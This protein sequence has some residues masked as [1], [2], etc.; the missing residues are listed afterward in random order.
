VETP[1][2]LSWLPGADVFDRIRICVV[3]QAIEIDRE[4]I[5]IDRESIEIDRKRIGIDRKS[6]DRDQPAINGDRNSICF[7]RELICVDE[8]SIGGDQ[9]TI[10]GNRIFIDDDSRPA[11][12]GVA[13]YLAVPASEANGV[14]W[15]PRSSKPLFRRG[16]VEGSVR[17]RPASAK[18]ESFGSPRVIACSL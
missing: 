1:R 5:D 2:G 7:D 14:W 18:F 6:I 9:K 16:S 11:G 12:L 8:E 3:R 13:C 10:D 4:R 17:F 15:L